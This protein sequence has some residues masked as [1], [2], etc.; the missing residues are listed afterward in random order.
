MLKVT[1]MLLPP[2]AEGK[3]CGK[4]LLAQ[5]LLLTWVTHM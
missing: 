2:E 4:E 1:Q 5:I 3:T